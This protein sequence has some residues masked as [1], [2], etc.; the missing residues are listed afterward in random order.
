MQGNPIKNCL[1]GAIG[2]A[3]E[4]YDFSV[5]GFSAPITSQIFVGSAD[6]VNNLIYVYLLFAIGFVS[7]PLGS[8][9][10]GYV[11]DRMGRAKMLKLTVWL[12][13]LPTI[14][15]GLMPGYA[16]WGMVVP[17]LIALL[18]FAQ[19]I[20]MGGEFT[21][22]IIYLVESAPKKNKG[23]FASFGYVSTTFGILLGSA[24]VAMNHHLFTHQQILDW[25]WR[26]PFIASAV[27]GIVAY[28]LRRN[29]PDIDTS[30][31]PPAKTHPLKELFTNYRREL[32]K[33]V[34]LNTSNAIGFYT[35]FIFMVT[36]LAHI[37]HLDLPFVLRLN[38][39]CLLVLT[40]IMPFSGW[41]I[42]RVGYKKILITMTTIL[43]IGTIPA[44]MIFSRA[45]HIEITITMLTISVIFGLMQGALP[46]AFVNLFPPHVRATGL[47]IGYNVSNALFGG[48]APVVAVWLIQVTDGYYAL[49][50]YLMIAMLI[51]IYTAVHLNKDS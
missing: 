8:F 3:I 23:L 15:I 9:L 13:T 42:G 26:L 32:Y 21:G 39:I 36:Y 38:T 35:F 12:M 16:S 18:R 51:F 46:L 7:R 34:G 25:G 24:V 44:F 2:N 5:F 17:L 20:A 30:T 1:G 4:W 27:V 45:D 43:F 37:L 31:F 29:L 10:F 6:H 33:T 19:G 47:S 11:G 41:L 48:T 14:L 50:G 22:S 40:L 49:T 28:I